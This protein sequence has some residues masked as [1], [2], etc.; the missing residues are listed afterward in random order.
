MDFAFELHTLGYTAAAMV[1][2]GAI[3][4]E[5]ELADKP[6]GM[7]THMLVSGA[8]ALLV[9]LGDKL[10]EHFAKY[11]GL[12]RAD[13]VGLI[14]ATVTGISFLGAGT[15]IRRGHERPVEGLTTA[16]SLLFTAVVGVCVAAHQLLLGVGATLLALVTLRTIRVIESRTRGKSRVPLRP[17]DP[18]P[19]ESTDEH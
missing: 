2:G 9:A 13:P 18:P 7:R 11:D 4:F 5:R 1:L 3:G 19:N 17:N 16:A 6:A 8:T 15:I 10:V 12:V 14:A